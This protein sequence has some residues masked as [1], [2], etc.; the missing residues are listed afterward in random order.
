MSVR[1]V[2]SLMLTCAKL[3]RGRLVT[4][5]WDGRR[6]SCVVAWLRESGEKAHE[7]SLCGRARRY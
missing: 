2:D 4:I 3:L 1:E 7:V 6:E 5:Q